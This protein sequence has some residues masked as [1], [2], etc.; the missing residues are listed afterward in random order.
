MKKIVVIALAGSVLIASCKKKH[1]EKFEEVDT[2]YFPCNGCTTK[3][4]TTQVVT[5]TEIS[6]PTPTTSATNY[7][8]KFTIDSYTTISGASIKVTNSGSA[9]FLDVPAFS[10]SLYGLPVKRVFLNG[11]TLAQ[12]QSAGEYWTMPNTNFMGSKWKVEGTSIFPSFTYSAAFAAPYCENINELPETISRISNTEIT[13]KISNAASAAFYLLDKNGKSIG[14]QLSPGVNKIVL[15][16]ADFL[17]FN[18][19]ETKITFMLSLYNL[20]NN[21]IG[22]KVATFEKHGAY[23]KE[24][25]FI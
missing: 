6:I 23:F 18:P 4:D 3:T 2:V 11:D 21:L 16:P 5:D 17:S 1:D 15:T 12:G 14:F 20:S 13:F 7:D 24:V 9:K 25:V 8:A 10:S 19:T 22:G